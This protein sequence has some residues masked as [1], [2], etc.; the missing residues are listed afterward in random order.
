MDY[1]PT[2]I[3]VKDKTVLVIGGTEDALHKVRLLRKSEAKIII[4]GAIVD[5]TLQQWIDEGTVFHKSRAVQKADLAEAAFAYIGVD[6]ADTRDHAI[7][8]F[9]QLKLPYSVIDDKARSS[10]IT[11]ALVD[12]DPVIVAI[13]TEGTGPIIARDIKA[14]IEEELSPLT[15]AIAKTAGAFRP[16]VEHLPQGGQRRKFWQRY[17]D[18]VV[19]HVEKASPQDPEKHLNEGLQHLLAE[20]E[21]REQ[22]A[23]KAA[24]PVQVVNIAA[25]DPDLMTRQALRCLHDADVVLFHHK[26]PKALFELTR[27]DASKQDWGDKYLDPGQLTKIIQAVRSG[28]SVAVMTPSNALP[29]SEDCLAEAGVEIVHLAFVQS[30]KTQSAYEGQVYPAPVIRRVS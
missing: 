8:L 10:F 12:R 24:K 21:L 25:G 28:Q 1:F 5:K 27:R 11:P 26:T 3:K 6:D 4:F 16:H 13:G 17:L 9:E 7:A 22:P 19:P 18:D 14:R 20:F 23:A 29:F 15:G 30:F 2:F